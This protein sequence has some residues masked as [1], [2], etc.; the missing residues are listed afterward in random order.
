M[1]PS[2]GGVPRIFTRLFYTFLCFLTVTSLALV[3]FKGK[4]SRVSD[5][6][7]NV[8]EW[9]TFDVLFNSLMI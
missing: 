1:N 9:S 8:T 4:K 7:S 6:S 5:G 3:R 2:Y